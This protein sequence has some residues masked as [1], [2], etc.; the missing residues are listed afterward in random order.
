MEKLRGDGNKKKNV[1]TANELQAAYDKETVN[2]HSKFVEEIK[3]Q[4]AKS[5]K[6]V[7]KYKVIQSGLSVNKP[8]FIYSSEFTIN[9]F[10]KRAGNNI[11]LEAGKL[12]GIYQK[13][14]QK[15]RDRK[16]DIY[17]PFARKIDYKFNINIPSGYK[18][19]DLSSFKKAISNEAGSFTSD[20]VLNGQSIAITVS[21]VFKHNFEKR[22]D[23]PKLLAIMDASAEFTSRKILFEKL[24]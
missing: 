14:D 19:S 10:V 2:Q 23:W 9:N 20:A 24:K 12:M 21:R 8:E 13:A 7:K 1:Q 4:Y 17:M 11:I 18:S 6:E 15:E 5:P 22:E 16:I 3:Q